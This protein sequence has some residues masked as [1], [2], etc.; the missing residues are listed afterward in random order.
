MAHASS[1]ALALSGF[2]VDADS[3]ASDALG[4]PAAAAAGRREREVAAGAAA[5]VTHAGT[6]TSRVLE[7][8]RQPG[9]SPEQDVEQLASLCF[10]LQSTVGPRGRLGG[11]DERR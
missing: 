1:L 3:E 11:D 5:L 10:A 4:A 8:W 9:Y 7:Q 2:T 6:L